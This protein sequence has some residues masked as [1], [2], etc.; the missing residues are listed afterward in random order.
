MKAVYTL[1]DLRDWPCP[2]MR[3]AV[4]GDPVA[5]SASPSMHNAALT[6]LG[7]PERYGRLW[8]RPDELAEAVR[9]LP[10][11]GFLGV[12]LTL[13]HKT[14]VLPLLDAVDPTPTGLAR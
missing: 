2:E 6:A 10:A 3:F 13:P 11:A 12:N 1:D 5:H 9:L 8:I 4:L 7:R 14:G